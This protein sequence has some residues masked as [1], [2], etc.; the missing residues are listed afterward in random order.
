MNYRF[1]LNQL[2]LLLAV[3]GAAM[4]LIALLDLVHVASEKAAEVAAVEALFIAA[5]IG[6]VAGGLVWLRTKRPSSVLGRREALL[7]VAASWFVGAALSGLP[8]FLWSHLDPAELARHPFRSPVNCYFEAM[9]GLTTT[10]ATVLKDIAAVP[11]S[12]LLWRAFTHWIGGLGIIVLFVAVFPTLGVGGKRLYRVEAPGPTP[13]GVRPHIRETARVL[14]FIYVGLS[15]LQIL[16]L[17]IAGASWFDSICHTFATLATGGFSPRNAS[18]GEL[19]SAWVDTI[20]IAFMIL[21][22]GNFG[23]YHQ[24]IT[25]KIRS[26]WKDPELRLYLSLLAGGSAVVVLSLVGHSITTT[27]GVALPPS[28]ESAIRY[29]VFTTVSIQTTTGFCTADFNQWPFIAKGVLVLLMFVGGSAGSTGG[30]IKVIRLWIAFKVMVAEIEKVFR[31]NVIRPIKLGN[32]PVDADLKLATLAYVLGMVVLV[33]AGAGAVMLVEP[34]SHD[35]SFTTAA[36]ASVATLCTIGPGLEQIGA[37]EHYGWFS[38]PSK[39]VLIILMAMG[40][41]EMFAVVVLFS[42]RFWKGT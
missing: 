5:A 21:A 8:Y 33:F 31:P 3:L 18:V 6:I 42:P 17:W 10:G 30:G 22:G 11:K 13:E 15:L 29:G 1:V 32:S 27:T 38:S 37:V 16:L 7:L 26:V 28:I 24:V 12:L 34:P 35:C 14:W 41:L 23:L 36:T 25:G 9:S 40:R 20:I 4:L 39:L 2:G 19:D